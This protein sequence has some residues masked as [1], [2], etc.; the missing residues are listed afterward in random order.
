MPVLVSVPPTTERIAVELEIVRRRPP[1]SA[2]VGLLTVVSTLSTPPLV[3]SIVAALVIGFVA[4]E[5]VWP[6]TLALTSP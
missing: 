6:L 2:P 4:R 3:A 5:S 1:G